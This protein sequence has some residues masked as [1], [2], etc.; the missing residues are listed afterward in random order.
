MK[1]IIANVPYFSQ[2]DNAILASTTCYATSMA[3]VMTYCLGLGGKTKK[4]VG[5]PQYAQLE[6]HLSTIIQSNETK[7]WIQR[8][9]SKYG[10]WFLKYKPRTLAGVQE[11]IFNMLMTPHGYKAKFSSQITYENYCNYIN[12]GY[13]VVIHGMFKS[14]SRVAG[15]IVVGIGYY[16]NE[17]SNRLIVHDPWGNALFDQYQSHTRGEEAEYDQFLLMRDWEEKKIWG[18]VIKPV[19]GVI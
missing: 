10:P 11:Y 19:E 14:V 5:C 7:L 2:T 4:D 1:T 9:W 13:P 18:Q 17:E 3:M 12:E 6:D 8:N 15:H 16:K